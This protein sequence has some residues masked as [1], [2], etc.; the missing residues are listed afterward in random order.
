MTVSV[1]DT[2]NVP[3][4]D[5]PSE[6]GR[7][8]TTGRQLVRVLTTFED[9]LDLEPAWNRVLADAD[10]PHPF[11]EHSWVRTWLECFGQKSLLR[12]VVVSSGSQPIAIA[13]LILT[14]VRMW[15]MPVR[16]LGLPYNDHVPRADFIVAR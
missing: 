2:L 14:A 4:L 3:T 10:I 16:Q 11:M 15:G 8:D 12:V 6:I 7:E 5:R 9:F 1:I 13:P